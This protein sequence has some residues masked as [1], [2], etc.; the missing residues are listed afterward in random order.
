[1]VNLSERI[2]E[3]KIQNSD[4]QEYLVHICYKTINFDYWQPSWLST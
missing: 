2:I 1:M 4:L 3:H